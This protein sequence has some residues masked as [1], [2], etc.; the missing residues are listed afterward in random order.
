MKSHLPNNYA[1]GDL[2][3]DLYK[4]VGQLEEAH[5]G[6]H[7]TPDGHLVGSLGEVFAA[8]EYGLELLEASHPVH[9]AKT[10]NGRRLVQIKTTQGNKI[11]IGECP[12]FLI[13]LRLSQNG[14]FEEVYNGP[15]GPVWD[16]VKGK[17]LPKNGQ[18]QISLNRL[19]GIASAIPDSKRIKR[20]R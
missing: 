6:R 16:L 1:H 17:K 2:I 20:V 12:D 7:F 19:R 11:G 15:G 4:I 13:V 14:T 3:R 9:D 5:P 8:E 18:H 10:R